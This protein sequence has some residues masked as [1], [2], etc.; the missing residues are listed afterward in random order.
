M[1]TKKKKTTYE[2]N[3]LEGLTFFK[4]GALQFNLEDKY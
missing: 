1:G 4:V 2:C 3:A